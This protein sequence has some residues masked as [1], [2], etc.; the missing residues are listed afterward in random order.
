LKLDLSK[1]KHISSDEKSTILE[2]SKGHRICLAHGGLAKKTVEALKAMAKTAIEANSA[3]EG[4]KEADERRRKGKGSEHGETIVVDK[5]KDKKEPKTYGKVILDP[6]YYAEGGAVDEDPMQQLVQSAKPE[7]I[8]S[9][10]PSVARAPSEV[11][12]APTPKNPVLLDSINRYNTDVKASESM[13]R[14]RLSGPGIP[15]Q[16]F[17]INPDGTPGPGGIRTDLWDKAKAE[18]QE[19]VLSKASNEQAQAKAQQ[20]SIAK[21]NAARAELGQPLLPDPSAQAPQQPAQAEPQSQP[22]VAQAGQQPQAPATAPALPGLA[23]LQT[24]LSGYK[25]RAQAQGALGN[26]EAE[27]LKRQQEAVQKAQDSFQQQVNEINQENEHYK[28]DIQNGFID[29]NKYWEGYT[30][31]NGTKVPGHSRVAAG[32]GMI[33]AGFGGVEGVKQVSNMIENQINRSLESQ[34]ANLNSSNNLLR[35][36]MDRFRDLK[37]ATN[38][39]RVQLNE[40]YLQ[41]LQAAA[42]KAQTPMAMAA[43]KIAMGPI[44]RENEQRMN[45]I[46]LN[47]TI[48]RLSKE[49]NPQAL[50]RSIDMLEQFDPARAKEMKGRLV[51]GLGLAT[52]LEGAKDLRE[53]QT[54][55]KTIKEGISRLRE[56]TKTTG[57]SMSPTLTKEAESIRTQLIGRLRVPLTGPG[58][59]SEGERELLSKAIPDVT[60]MV[61]LDSRTNKAL[62]TLEKGITSGYRNMAIANG[63]NVPGEQMSSRQQQAMEWLKKNPNHKDAPAIRN[64]LGIK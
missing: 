6:K 62:D 32:I 24:E 2:H 10:D 45:S 27:I 3:A 13:F 15:A 61:S 39:T 19:A 55:V 17:M 4:V 41:Q 52:T 43:A 22:G 57:K 59:M 34:K 23:G 20:E 63:L 14:D 33:L 50:E 37:D 5:D 53:M 1:L 25:E 49:G 11:P 16:E 51:T 28:Q 44:M 7:P 29:P 48:S 58:A 47:Q 30:A 46:A 42:A 18:A 26:A 56:I 54:T 21:Q 12:P 38:M 64:S 36:N 60:S 8:M 31:A 35:A 40:N 9:E